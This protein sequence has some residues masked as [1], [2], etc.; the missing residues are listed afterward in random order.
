VVV[1]HPGCPSI[2]NVSFSGNRLQNKCRRDNDRVFSALASP[3]VK[4]VVLVSR[5]KSAADQLHYDQNGHA[6]SI[7]GDKSVASHDFGPIFKASVEALLDLGK[8]VL[9]V[10][11]IPEPSFDVPGVTARNIAWG[12]PL[13]AEQTRQQFLQDEERVLSPLAE[14]SHRDGVRVVYPHLVLCD[15][16]S[17]RYQKA[18]EPLYLDGNHLSAAGARELD[19]IYAAFFSSASED[20]Q[21]HADEGSPLT[22]TT[23][24]LAP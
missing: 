24:K 14:L 23:P 8:K 21:K 5:W 3:A 11:P 15:D 2:V 20:Q 6:V 16:R 19:S 9:I 18:G 1:A 12:V 10:G 17:C 13:P 7:R 4:R 22:E